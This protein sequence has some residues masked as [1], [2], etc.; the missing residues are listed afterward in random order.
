MR[1]MFDDGMLGG[2]E[3]RR[4][5]DTFGPWGPA[6]GP[7]PGA[8]SGHRG[9]GRGHGRRTKR[10]NVRAA[11]LAL[12]AERPMHGYEMI[13]ELESRTAGVWRPSPGSV[14]PTLQMLEDEGLVSSQEEGGKRLFSLTDTGREEAGRQ[15]VPPWEEVT[16]QAGESAMHAREEIGRLM[17]AMQ[18]VMVAGSEEQRARALDLIADTRRKL[19]G[20]LADDPAAE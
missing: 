18:Q 12:L 10:G 13:Q 8:W 16:E 3:G 5:R 19:Y 9:R 14:Y 2:P 7:G 6:F 1:R 20:I 15:A 4:R 11:M 17:G